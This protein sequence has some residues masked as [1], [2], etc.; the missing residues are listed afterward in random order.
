MQFPKVHSFPERESDPE[1]R[2]ELVDI[3][4]LPDYIH[5]N[6]PAILPDVTPVTLLRDA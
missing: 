2:R 5:A 6:I 3:L 1:K 4:V